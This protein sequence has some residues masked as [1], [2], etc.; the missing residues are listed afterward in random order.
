MD[1]GLSVGEVDEYTLNGATKRRKKRIG[2]YSENRL[3]WRHFR[4]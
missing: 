3:H 2:S 1:I 4:A